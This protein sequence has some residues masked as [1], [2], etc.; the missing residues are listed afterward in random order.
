MTA[1]ALPDR[2]VDDDSLKP[3]LAGGI[4]G[5]LGGAIW[6]VIVAVTDYEVGW[7]AWGVGGLVGWAMT[8]AT[9]QRS[10][11]L[12]MIAAGLAVL[13]LLCGKIFIQYFVTR[14][15]FEQAVRDD[16]DAIGSALAAKMREEST[17]PPEIQTQLDELGEA[18]TVS[19]A[20]WRSMVA[21]GH[22]KAAE[23]TE[24][25]RTAV[26]G[27]YVAS[28][29]RGVGPWQQLAWGFSLY[30]LLWFGL[31]VSTAWRMLKHQPPEPAPAAA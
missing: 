20:L 24:E 31:A 28:V 22:Q 19:D 21:A 1:S 25:E 29:S 17:F 11:R 3:I 2:Q 8:K 27:D 5:V 15:A 23:L 26:L 16:T 7:V 13:G 6:A 30:D 18:D 4:A 12:A 9:Q 14:P 10:T